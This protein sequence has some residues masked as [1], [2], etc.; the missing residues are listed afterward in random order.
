MIL[1]AI[2]TS[3]S[4]PP[5]A[6]ITADAVMTAMM[7]KNAS[8]GGTPGSVPKTKIRTAVP[9]TPTDRDRSPR[10]GPR[11]RWPA[12]RPHLPG[13]PARSRS[14]THSLLKG[15]M[16]YRRYLVRGRSSRKRFLTPGERPRQ[17][18]ASAPRSRPWRPW[19]M[20]WSGSLGLH[21]APW[22]RSGRCRLLPRAGPGLHRQH[23]RERGAA[24]LRCRR[25]TGV[26]SAGAHRIVGGVPGGSATGPAESSAGRPPP[27]SSTPR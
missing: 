21:R 4:M 16:H 13:L 17:G 3:Q 23:D 24:G 26:A 12:G 1:E 14:R 25:G 8:T 7:M 18:R 6:C 19:S 15:H 11:E 2:D 5:A 22:S 20:P 9:A 27:R 10:F